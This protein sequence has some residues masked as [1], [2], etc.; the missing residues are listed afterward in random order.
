VNQFWKS[1]ALSELSPTEWESLCDGCGRCCLRKLE[2]A[3]TGTVHYTD[4]A[5]RLLASSSCRCRNYTHRTEL[6][7]DCA[8]LTAQTLEQLAWMPTTCAYRLVYEGR[9]LPEWHPL[10]SGNP[11]SVH[12]AG[13]SV[14]GRVVSEA[15]IDESEV[16]QRLIDWVRARD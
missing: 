1:R 15:F 3:D 4:V 14:R 6:V 7:A 8:H 9:D 10:V 5:C 13:I 16:E 12:A 2:D 11:E